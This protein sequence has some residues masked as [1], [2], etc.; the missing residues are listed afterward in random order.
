MLDFNAYLTA[1]HLTREAVNDALPRA[2][3]RP[4]RVTITRRPGGIAAR[5]WLSL[6]LRRLA[7]VVEVSSPQRRGSAMRV[8]S[9]HGGCC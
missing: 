2:T 4:D 6:A 5:Q 7:N 3:V 8:S 1:Q 9:A